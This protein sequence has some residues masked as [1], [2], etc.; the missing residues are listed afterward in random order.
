MGV[1]AKGP[2]GRNGNDK[3]R[4][5]RG[6]SS[7]LT[8][9]LSHLHRPSVFLLLRENSGLRRYTLMFMTKTKVSGGVCVVLQ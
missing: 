7:F 1:C 9:D 6:F 5:E 2:D 8:E 4:A 3:C